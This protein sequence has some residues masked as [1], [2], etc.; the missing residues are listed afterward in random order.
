LFLESIVNVVKEVALQN[1]I[2]KG[3]SN[4][5][6]LPTACDTEEIGRSTF[7]DSGFP[8]LFKKIKGGFLTLGFSVKYFSIIGLGSRV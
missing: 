7:K 2:S 6:R 3:A 1:R 4:A 8:F 5:R